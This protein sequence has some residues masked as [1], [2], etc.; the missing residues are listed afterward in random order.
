VAAFVLNV[1]LTRAL[2]LQRP[3][4]AALKALGYGNRALGWHYMKWALVIALLGVGV[5]VTAGAWLGRQIIDLYN[6]YFKFPVLLYRLSWDVVVG[7]AAMTTVAAVLGALSA[8]RRAVAVPP[9]EAMRPE[10]PA[11]YRRSVLESRYLAMSLS[12]TTRMVLRNIA[13]TPFRATASVVGIAFAAAILVV[14]VGFLDAFDE[15]ITTQFYRAERQ[16]VTV[17]FVEP[18]SADARHALARLPGV[19]AVEAQRVVPARIRV[20]H[21]ERTISVTGVPSTPRLRR[22][23]TMD[24]R[25]IRLPPAGLVLSSTLAH[26]LSVA[27]GDFVELEVLEGQRPIRRVLVSATV[28]DVLGLSAYM[29]LAALHQMLGEGEVVSGASILIDSADEADLSTALK[30][31]PAVA[32]VGFKRA[33]LENFRDVMAANMNISIFFN[34]AFA[35]I[36]AFGVV[37]NAARV[38][39]SERSREL[40][41]LRVLGFTRAEISFILLGELAVLTLAALPLGALIGYGMA[42][43]I[44]QSLDSEVY[45][46][47]LTVSRS[48]FAW[49]FLT[50]IAAATASGLSVRRHLDRL[51]LV[52]VLK[53]RE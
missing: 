25:P 30:R 31:L 37:Y 40:A 4:L 13:R 1:A 3:Q 45:R 39:L 2:A 10:A 9:A 18:R 23:V 38:S 52:A 24:G 43:A 28:D 29:D 8:V 34:V 49:T 19:I 32:G 26:V 15:L 42:S 48:T 22:I 50:I 7:A 20:A 16:D 21:R 46:F 53:I 44:V 12:T 35:G 11:L 17:T 33:V 14:G 5:G 36:I 6:Q 41:S 47:P 27:P 51:D